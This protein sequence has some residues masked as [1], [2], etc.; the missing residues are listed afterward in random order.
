M[1][2]Q[3]VLYTQ[4]FAGPAHTQGTTGSALHAGLYALCTIHRAVQAQRY[5]QGCK[6]CT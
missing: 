4:G 6:G 1:A 3:A 2:V 5:T